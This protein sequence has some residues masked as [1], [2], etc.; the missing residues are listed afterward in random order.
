MKYI[1]SVILALYIISCGSDIKLQDGE[2]TFDDEEKCSSKD[3]ERCNDNKIQTCIGEY[4]ATI[5]TCNLKDAGD[6]C[7]SDA[8]PTCCK[9]D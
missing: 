8:G 3:I 2:I 5:I 9:G 4:W 6:C 1:I 7:E